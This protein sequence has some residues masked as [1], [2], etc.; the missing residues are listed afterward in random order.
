VFDRYNGCIP[1][2]PVERRTTAAI[3]KDFL[4]IQVKGIQNRKRI[5]TQPGLFFVKKV[6]PSERRQPPKNVPALG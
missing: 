2:Q 6:I 1:A 3:L 4:A 5:K